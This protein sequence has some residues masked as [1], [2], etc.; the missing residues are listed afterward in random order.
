[1]NIRKKKSVKRFDNLLK[2]NIARKNLVLLERS[3]KSGEEN[4]YGFLLRVSEGFILIHEYDDFELNGYAIIR[5]DQFESI[6]SNKFDRARRKMMNR[7]GTLEVDLG[8]RY[9]IVLEDWVSIF[10]SLKKQNLSV[11]VECEE[12][13]NAGFT[14]GPIEEVNKNSVSIRHFDAAGIL[15]Q[16]S[17][18]ISFEDITIIRFDERYINVYSKYLR[19]KKVKKK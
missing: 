2:S 1:M 14:I 11:I 6:R 13:K 5:Q 17:T 12:Q 7:E 19:E 16:Q 4:V 15:A 9:E 8:I 18:R 10:K 3:F